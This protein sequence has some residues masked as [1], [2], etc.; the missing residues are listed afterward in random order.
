[1]KFSGLAALAAVAAAVVTTASSA[2][3][4]LTKAQYI[5]KLRAANALSAKADDAAGAA[6]GSKKSTPAR[7]RALF[8]VMGQK[9]VAIGREFAALVPPPSAAQANAD[10]AR[11][12]ITFGQQN[13]AIAAKLPSTKRALLKYIESLKPPSGG[14]LLDRAIAELHAAGF[15]I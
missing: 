2:A 8:M 4:P 14:K 9:H 11:A 6:L 3:A 5:A 12:E 15:R 10:F 7:V 13:E 1:L